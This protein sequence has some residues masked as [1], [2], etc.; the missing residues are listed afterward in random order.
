MPSALSA[1]PEGD[2]SDFS[3]HVEQ[4]VLAAWQEVENAEGLSKELVKVGGDQR[5]ELAHAA[6]ERAAAAM[7]RRPGAWPRH[8]VALRR[9][10]DIHAQRRCYLRGATVGE[11]AVLEEGNLGQHVEL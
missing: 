3:G 11:Y 1:I 2:E 8:L 7:G 9:R 10:R 5:Q 4:A 6:I